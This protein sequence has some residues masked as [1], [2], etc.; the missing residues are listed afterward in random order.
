MINGSLCYYT[1]VMNV[2]VGHWPEYDH[3]NNQV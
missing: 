2:T 3:L 1:D